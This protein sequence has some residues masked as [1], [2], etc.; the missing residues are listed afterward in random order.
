MKKKDFLIN[1]L[2]VFVLISILMPMIPISRN[3]VYAEDPIQIRC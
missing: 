2:A 1:L 3:T